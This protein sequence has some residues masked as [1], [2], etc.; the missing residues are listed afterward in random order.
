MSFHF[1]TISLL[2]PENHNHQIRLYKRKRETNY[3]E[4][5]WY[6]KKQLLQ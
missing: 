2:L 6:V 3:K 1:I 5:K 4:E